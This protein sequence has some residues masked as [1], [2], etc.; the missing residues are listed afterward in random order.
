MTSLWEVTDIAR[1]F[2]RLKGYNNDTGNWKESMV[3]FIEP[4]GFG[5]LQTMISTVKA[6]LVG[7][8]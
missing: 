5:N 4:G 3:N 2:R 8:L 6:K 7:N 1:I